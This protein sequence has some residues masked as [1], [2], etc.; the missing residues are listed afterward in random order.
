[1]VR[2]R[3]IGITPIKRV[4]SNGKEIGLK[5]QDPASVAVRFCLPSLRMWLTGKDNRFRPCA[6]A[7]VEVRFLPSSYDGDINRIDERSQPVITGSDS[8]HHL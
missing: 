7:A 6:L 1:M 4:C 8:L 5:I 2:F 3:K